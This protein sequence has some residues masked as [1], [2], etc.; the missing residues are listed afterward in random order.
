MALITKIQSTIAN[1]A[2]D[3]TIPESGGE[4]EEKKASLTSCPINVDVWILTSATLSSFSQCK[5]QTEIKL[6]MFN[7]MNHACVYQVCITYIQ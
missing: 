3:T 7:R 6:L 5:V 1:L 4:K 2:R